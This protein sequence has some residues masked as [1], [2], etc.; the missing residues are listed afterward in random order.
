MYF[1]AKNFIAK[2]VSKHLSSFFSS[3]R[4]LTGGGKLFILERHFGILK[5]LYCHRRT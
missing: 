5:I 2:V 4:L 3:S 1:S